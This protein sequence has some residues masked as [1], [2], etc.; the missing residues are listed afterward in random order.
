MEQGSN[1]WHLDKTF[2]I[3]HLI[4]TLVIAGSVFV[5]AGSMDK[6][7]TIVENEIEHA[8]D[9]QNL[10]RAEMH[11]NQEEIKRSLIRIEAKLDSKQD[12]Q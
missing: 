9:A 11:E 7:V 10:L 4:S 8:K 12:K 3:S 2:S 6:R 5:W 1:H